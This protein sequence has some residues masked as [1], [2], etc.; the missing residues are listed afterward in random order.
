MVLHAAVCYSSVRDLPCPKS[1]QSP[2]RIQ[3]V[4]NE[5]GGG[6]GGDL[7]FHVCK[8]C[9][10]EQCVVLMS[11]KIF[12]KMVQLGKLWCIFLSDFALII[13]KLL[14]FILNRSIYRSY[15]YTCYV[16]RKLSERIL[17]TCDN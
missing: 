17:K 2:L 8:F 1:P 11:S 15:L 10:V 7:L 3:L 9:I 4:T 12:L 6:V 14:I 13:F 5:G 16:V